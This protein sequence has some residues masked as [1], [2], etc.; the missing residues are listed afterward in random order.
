M[1][2]L[3]SICIFFQIM[4][5]KTFNLAKPFIHLENSIC[6]RQFKNFGHAR[7]QT[8]KIRT[9]WR[10]FLVISFMACFLDYDA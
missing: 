3:V 5:R 2:F 10:N 9:I 1:N 7:E 8:S 4:L 6:A